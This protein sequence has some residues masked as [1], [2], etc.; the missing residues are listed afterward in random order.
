MKIVT[1]TCHRAINHGAM[2][3][4]YALVAYLRSCG[5]DVKIIDYIPYYMRKVRLL[6]GSPRYNKFGLGL[7]YAI[8]KLPWRL[9]MRRDARAFNLFSDKYLP[10]TSTYL[11]IDELR[12]NPPEADCYIA[13][14]DQIWNTSFPNGSDPCYYLDFGSSNILK[15]SYAASFATS[16]IEQGKENLVQTFLKNFNRI[17]VRE[18]SALNILST[19]GLKGC[20]V[21]DPIFLLNKS[22]WDLLVSEEKDGDSD[23]NNRYVLVYDFMNDSIISEIVKRYARLN[24][25]MIYSIFDNASHYAN[26][27]FQ[28]YGPLFFVK[29]IKN[30]QCVISNSFH[31][32]AFSMLYHRPFWVI[33]RSDGL[34]VRMKDLLESYNLQCRLINNTVTNIQLLQDIDYEDVSAKLSEDIIKSKQFLTF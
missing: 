9:K 32:T 12:N 17:S 24:N 23:I 4:A 21:V 11:S 30:A 16:E 14:S 31:G 26:K 13:G 3:Q 1:I 15:V 18:K 25:C 8:F 33:N 10:K 27:C 29:L 2:L 19:M 20:R 5:H 6:Q 7:L 28:G 34:N 22:D